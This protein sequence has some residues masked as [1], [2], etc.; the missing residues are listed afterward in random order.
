MSNYRP[1]SKLSFLSKVLEKVISAQLVS[2]M[3][4]NNAFNKFQPGFRALHSTETALVK[5][6]NN[7]LLAADRGDSSV[8]VL[9]DLSAAFHTVV[10]CILLHRL[11][12]WVGITGPALSLLQSYL[13]NRIFSVALGN[14]SSSSAQLRWGSLKA[15]SLA[16]FCFPYTCYLSARLSRIM[17]CF[18]ISMQMILSCTCHL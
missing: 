17:M 2:S 1:I 10:H 4:N 6:T 16:F 9:L 8:L 18:T 11:E 13:S 15:L 14:V 3:N 7:L 12:T 5:V